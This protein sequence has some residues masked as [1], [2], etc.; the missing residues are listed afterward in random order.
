[1]EKLTFYQKLIIEITKCKPTEVVEVEYLMRHAILNSTLDWLSKD[2]FSDAVKQAYELYKELRGKLIK[3][4]NI[5]YY[6]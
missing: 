1:M 2:Q 3:N 5:L 4:E 6:Q